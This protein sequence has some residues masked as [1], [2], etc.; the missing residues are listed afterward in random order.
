M[1]HALS[2]LGRTRT[3]LQSLSSAGSAG[4]PPDLLSATIA[5]AEADEIIQRCQA[6][7]RHAVI[8]SLITITFERMMQASWS[9]LLEACEGTDPDG[10]WSDHAARAGLRITGHGI[11]NLHAAA[12]RD[13][14]TAFARSC[15]RGMAACLW[16]GN[17]DDR[18]AAVAACARRHATFDRYEDRAAGR[19]NKAMKVMRRYAA[20][21][22]SGVDEHEREGVEAAPYTWLG[23]ADPYAVPTF[24]PV[25]VLSARRGQKEPPAINAFGQVTAGHVGLQMAAHWRFQDHWR[26][27][28]SMEKVMLVPIGLGYVT[29]ALRD[30]LAIKKLT[31]R[32]ETFFNHAWKELGMVTFEDTVELLHPTP[33]GLRPEMMEVIL[34]ALE[35]FSEGIERSRSCGDGEP[36]HTQVPNE[37]CDAQG[38]GQ[39][40]HHSGVCTPTS[41]SDVDPP[42][43][44]VL[45]NEPGLGGSADIGALQEQKG[46]DQLRP[47]VGE[48][49]PP[50]PV[51]PS[52][53]PGHG[54]EQ[55][56]EQVHWHSNA[57]PS[58][59]YNER[60]MPGLRGEPRIKQPLQTT[61]GPVKVLGPAQPWTPGDRN[62]APYF[63][64]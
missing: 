8:L 51:L 5:F 43:N 52:E 57:G 47:R 21:G 3:S 2:I 29:W 56:Q 28:R 61:Q 45:P 42:R 1:S 63:P 15:S 35:E 62:I 30:A 9:G 59:P 49:R 50:E 38:T 60:H 46:N 54:H 39:D 23:E 31:R 22:R 14:M 32:T 36:S 44:D 4:I 7:K 33:R 26:V 20:L 53:P 64:P 13:R 10:S 12:T 11:T 16:I 55:V 41:T 58:V 24:D 34:R 19:R 25:E 6:M 40:H 27:V 37:P 48:E 17:L 18:V